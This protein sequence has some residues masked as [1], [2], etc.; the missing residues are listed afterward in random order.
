[1]IK[2]MTKV[3]NVPL[4]NNN[5]FEK[6]YLSYINKW[7]KITGYLGVLVAFGPALVLA[8]VFN[9]MPPASAIL[10]GFITMA[11]AVGV[12]WFVEPI[13]YF[14]II[15]VAGTYMAFISGN[16]SNLRIPA[17]AIAQKV[18]E[19]EPGTKEGNIIST[20]GI[21][22]S[23]VVNIVILSLGVFAGTG[24]LDRLPENVLS[25]F[26]FLLPALFGAI[27]VQFALMKLKLAPIA[28]IIAISLT[29]GV[30]AGLFD[31]LP[32]MPGYIITLGSVF[33][34]IG[35]AILIDKKTKSKEES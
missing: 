5:D 27:F 28:L 6:N 34:T 20:L 17:S 1:M 8:V 2:T 23:I 24:I 32:G 10:T 9:I 29:L 13:S 25:A 18:A 11:S 12:V 3:G 26:N 7:G 30:N 19:V 16:I 21:A 4:E 33:G 14:P 15:G 31:F 22:V 35:L